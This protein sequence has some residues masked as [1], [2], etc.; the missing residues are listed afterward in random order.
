MADSIKILLLLFIGTDFSYNQEILVPDT[1]LVGMFTEAESTEETVF[2]VVFSN[3]TLNRGFETSRHFIP[4]FDAFRTTELLCRRLAGGMDIVYTPW[5]P[6]STEKIVQSYLSHFSVPH[7][8]SSSRSSSSSSSAFRLL[9]PIGNA[10]VDLVRHLQWSHTRILYEYDQDLEMLGEMFNMQYGTSIT[11]FMKQVR[12]WN[13]IQALFAKLKVQAQETRFIVIASTLKTLAILRA[14]EEVQMLSLNYHYI[15]ANLD[16][17]CKKIYFTYTGQVNLTCLQIVD[18][19]HPEVRQF[20]KQHSLAPLPSRL[21]VK[22]LSRYDH[23]LTSVLDLAIA[24][25]A[26]KVLRSLQQISSTG[27]AQWKPRPRIISQNGEGEEDGMMSCMDL[28]VPDTRG[29]VLASYLQKLRVSGISGNV[30]FDERGERRNYKIDIV[31]LKRVSVKTVIGYWNDSHGLH[32]FPEGGKE[33]SDVE[34]QSDVFKEKPVEVVTIEAPPFTMLKEGHS[35]DEGIEAFE[36][37]CVDLLRE[38]AAQTNMSYKIHLVRD[39]KYGASMANGSWN[40]MVGELIDG[41]ADIALAPLTITS[42]RQRVVD[43]TKPYMDVGVSIMM[44]RSTATTSSFSFLRPLQTE[45]WMCI[46]FSYLSVS[47]VLFIVS[48]ISLVAWM[49]PSEIEEAEHA[50][51]VAGGGGEYQ[52]TLSNCFFLMLGAVLQRGEDICDKLVSPLSSNKSKYTITSAHGQH[53]SS[54]DEKIDVGFDQIHR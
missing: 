35:P 52:F 6:P 24:L 1:V 49:P 27:L 46:V 48:R 2:D 42:E 30:Q 5:L 53:F 41:T 25:D 47:V 17:P 15:I 19:D 11:V 40:G 22:N 18:A 51:G 12:S 29:K 33:T 43:F 26:T 38:I 14:A 44:K 34:D 28:E 7:L 13:S 54:W 23:N 4:S 31:S 45:I 9:P 39:G 16:L 32:I 10:V 50:V 8:L 20:V 3:S 37:F 36:G 21:S